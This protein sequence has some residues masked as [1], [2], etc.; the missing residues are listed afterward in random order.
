VTILPPTNAEIVLSKLGSDTEIPL[1]PASQPLDP[2]PGRYHLDVFDHRRAHVGVRVIDVTGRVR[3]PGTQ[4]QIAISDDPNAAGQTLRSHDF[5]PALF[6]YVR[7]DLA[8][9]VHYLV[10][11]IDD[12]APLR[13]PIATLPNRASLITVSLD[14]RGAPRLQQFIL[15]IGHLAEL[16]PNQGRLRAL[17]TVRRLVDIQ[18][19][20]ARSQELSELMPGDGLEL[21]LYFKWYEPIASVLAAYELARRGRFDSL[22]EVVKNLRRYFPELPDSEAIAK[23][24]GLDYVMPQSPPL[25]LEGLLSLDLM[26]GALPFGA[27]SLDYRGP[28]TLWR[29]F[30][31]VPPT[32]ASRESLAVSG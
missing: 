6:E 25:V 16:L 12:T 4:L 30:E 3:F 11:Q 21:I 15:P 19:A 24:A 5:F 22:P 20:F 23:L 10:V 7:P 13:L 18:R 29:G 32:G 27:E 14:E 17:P 2:A 28:W 26:G 9:G 31:D 1:D 8:C